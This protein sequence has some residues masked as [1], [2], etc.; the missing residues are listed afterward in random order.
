MNVS[1][2]QLTNHKNNMGTKV[3]DQILT[4]MLHGS[5]EEKHYI[6]NESDIILECKL[7]RNLFRA[8]TGFIL[9]RK[10]LCLKP[11]EKS[12]SISAYDQSMRSE[13]FKNVTFIT[14]V[15]SQDSQQQQQQQQKDFTSEFVDQNGLST[16]DHFQYLENYVSQINE[17]M[18]SKSNLKAVLNL[19]QEGTTDSN[20]GE[21]DNMADDRSKLLE[22]YVV[23]IASS[24]VLVSDNTDTT[25]K[26]RIVLTNNNSPQVCSFF[27]FYLNF[28]F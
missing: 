3:I 16:A 21:Q 18:E 22:D 25:R 8:L 19:T 26:N 10:S 11:I 12:V 23:Q 20:K 13:T 14:S 9:H 4:K 27:E 5:P 7:C 28:T 1:Y 17:T 2:L 15:S 24:P 6:Y